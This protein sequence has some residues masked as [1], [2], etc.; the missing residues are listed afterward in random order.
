VG[1]DRVNR[2]KEWHNVSFVSGVRSKAYKFYSICDIK[3]KE[4]DEKII[5]NLQKDTTV[6]LE[7]GCGHGQ[8]LIKYASMVKMGMGIDISETLINH[9]QM[10]MKSQNVNNLEF[11]V[12][13]AMNTSFENGY[14]DIIHGSAIL[15]HLDLK[16]SLLEIKRILKDGGKA[17]F[18]EPLDTNL[19]IKIYR[20]MT[21]EARTVDEQP[22][23]RKDIKLIKSLFPETEIIYYG[24]L[25]LLAVPFRNYKVFNKLLQIF[26]SMDKILLNKYSPFKWLG[27]CCT[28][29]LKK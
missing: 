20:K 15:H 4:W 26:Y 18:D 19:L 25:L 7:Y 17:F 16:K 27:W 6:F 13:D 5:K 28:I 11:S 24:C 14:F 8:Y 21:P 23:R 12:M 10:E 2:E 3:D 22:L 9:A 1:K 29:V